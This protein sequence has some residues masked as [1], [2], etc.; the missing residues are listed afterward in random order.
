M[1]RGSTV[2][3]VCGRNSSSTSVRSLFSTRT[4]SSMTPRHL[5]LTNKKQK[6]QGYSLVVWTYSNKTNCLFSKS[7]ASLLHLTVKTSTLQTE[8][9]NSSAMTR[10]SSRSSSRVTSA[11]QLWTTMRRMRTRV[12]GK[13]ETQDKSM[14]FR[15]ILMNSLTTSKNNNKNSISKRARVNM[16]LTMLRFKDWKT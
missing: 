14:L 6:S 4:P 5:N 2:K 1:K 11:R 9:S 16:T 12:K 8:W 13:E 15:T 3:N 7:K 10:K